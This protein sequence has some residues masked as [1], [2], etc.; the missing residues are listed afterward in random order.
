MVFAVSQGAK[1]S[2]RNVYIVFK[3]L[4]EDVHSN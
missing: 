1:V 3:S 4:F 2:V